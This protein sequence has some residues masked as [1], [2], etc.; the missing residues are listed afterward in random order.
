MNR[1]TDRPTGSTRSG[2][3][4]LGS[5]STSRSLIARVRSR[6]ADAWNR[7]VALYAPFVHRHCRRSLPP[8]DAADVFQEVFQ[9]A[10]KRIESF[11]KRRPG[12]T[13]RGW[14]VASRRVPT[15]DGKWMRFLTLEDKSGLAEIV[16]FPDVYQR[17]GQRLT[18]FGVLC[19][20][21]LVKSQMGA[22]TLEAQ[23]IW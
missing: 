18:E 14:L 2:R 6:D 13:L 11:D 1:P 20:T 16:L 22:C 12:D 5:T 10:F 19:V 15:S 4:G 8:E 3:E 7:F 9:A 17:D 23:R 21:G